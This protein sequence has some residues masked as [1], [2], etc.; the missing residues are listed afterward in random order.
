MVEDGIFLL[1]LSFFCFCIPLCYST[2][3]W[4]CCIDYDEDVI[5]EDDEEEDEAFFFAGQGTPR[6]SQNFLA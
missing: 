6:N 2:Y 4:L 5:F 3:M 1:N